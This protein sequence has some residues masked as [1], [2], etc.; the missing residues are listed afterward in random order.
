MQ[1]L[2]SLT[3]EGKC[4][5]FV[6]SK[7]GVDELASNL[8]GLGDAYP[9]VSLHGDKSQYDRADALRRF[10][11]G[12]C[13]ILVATDVAARGLDIKEIKNVVNYDVAKTIDIHVHRIG[14]T[15]RMGIDGV[16]PGTAFTLVV[17]S[18]DIDFAGQLVN[19]M[20]LSNQPV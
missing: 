20:D 13:P 14:R 5:I 11:S 12:A 9:C 6:G 1:T 7:A 16:S 4:L 3:E 18:K 19:N 15:G 17:V 2:P 10:K 8:H